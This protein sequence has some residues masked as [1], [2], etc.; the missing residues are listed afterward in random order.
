VQV[1]VSD[2]GAEWHPTPLGIARGVEKPGYIQRIGGHH[3]L[4]VEAAPH[5]PGPVGVDLDAEVI[6][7]LEIERLTHEVIGLSHPN[8]EVSQV[9]DDPA[10]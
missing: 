9:P 10:E 3:Q 5:F 2:G 8:A 1:N 6:G 7:I 4:A